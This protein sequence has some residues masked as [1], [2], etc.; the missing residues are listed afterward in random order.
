MSGTSAMDWIYLRLKAEDVERR[1]AYVVGASMLVS[2]QFVQTIGLM[3]E[4]YFLYS[5]EIDWA[6]RA[7][8]SFLLAY[9]PASVVYHKEGGSTGAKSGARTRNPLVDYYGCRSR[10]VFTLRFVKL[11]VPTVLVAIGLSVVR[12]ALTGRFRSAS[13]M[14]RAVVD[15]VSQSNRRHRGA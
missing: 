15:A 11:A 1:M 3:E 13:T 2:R 7:K 5:E 9:A 10:L 6:T 14:M 4:S 12:Q 8:G